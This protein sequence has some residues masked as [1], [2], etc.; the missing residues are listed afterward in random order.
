[1]IEHHFPK[2]IRSK[3][4]LQNFLQKNKE[5]LIAMKREEFKTADAIEAPYDVDVQFLDKTVSG[6]ML[7]AEGGVLVKA[8]ADTLKADVDEIVVPCI[9]NTTNII[10]SY[11]DLHIPKMWN[12]SLKENKNMLHL[13]EH[14]MSF[15][16]IISDGDDLK[17]FVQMYSWKELGAKYPGETEGL[18][19]LS[20]IKSERNLYMFE[21]YSKKRVKNHSVGMRPIKVVMAIGNKDFGAEFEA[22]EKYLPMAVNPEV[23][24]DRG[25]FWAIPE[26][27]AIEGSA[28]PRGANVITPALYKLEPFTEHSDETT[29]DDQPVLPLIDYEFLMKNF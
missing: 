1:M 4:Q 17:A 14:R 16:M 28:V 24:E 22:W 20:S 8:D 5:A 15:D 9:I 6:I 11:L 12:K 27:K 26:G 19:F 21:Q 2:E 3:L 18:T 13:R 25:Y 23:A 7:K 29:K 10:D